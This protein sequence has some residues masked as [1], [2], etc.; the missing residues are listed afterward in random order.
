MSYLPGGEERLI[1]LQSASGEQIEV[2]VRPRVTCAEF[3]VLLECALAGLGIA[4]VPRSVAAAAIASGRL[5]IVL[6]EWRLP[7]GIFHVVFPHRRGLLP[8]VRAF[9]DFLVEK[10]PGVAGGRGTGDTAHP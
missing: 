8:A 3:Q 1:C 10:M 9:I 5:A 4:H 7:L 2:A 6:P